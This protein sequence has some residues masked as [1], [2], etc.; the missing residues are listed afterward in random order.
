MFGAPTTITTRSWQNYSTPD[1]PKT[2]LGNRHYRQL[3]GLCRLCVQGVYIKPCGYDSPLKED[4][5]SLPEVG[6]MAP[7]RKI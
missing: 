4:Y 3:S 7:F 1:T 6:G 5:G 2:S